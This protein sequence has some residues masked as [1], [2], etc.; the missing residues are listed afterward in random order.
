MIVKR[1]ELN[2]WERLYLP[3]IAGGFKVTAKHFVNTLF[4]RNSAAKE[5]TGGFLRRTVSLKQRVDEMLRGHLEPA[6]NRRQVKALPK[7]QFF[8]FN[9]HR[10]VQLVLCPDEFG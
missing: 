2:F 1:K 3:A 6:R 8:A 10:S 9:D 4:N 5:T 7:V